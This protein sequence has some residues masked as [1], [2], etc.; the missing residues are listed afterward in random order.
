[1]GVLSLGDDLPVWGGGGRIIYSVIRYAIRLIGEKP[2]LIKLRQSFDHG[3]N[4][5]DLSDLTYNELTEFR[6]ATESYT[7]NRQWQSEGFGDCQ[8]LMQQLLDL[9]DARLKQMTIH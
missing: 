9:I 3:Y 7:D 5:A 4:H 8:D 2:H 1:M 6:H